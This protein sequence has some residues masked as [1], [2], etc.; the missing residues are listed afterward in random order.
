M[1]RSV[2]AASLAAL[3]GCTIQ[4]SPPPAYPAQQPQTAQQEPP[5]P[6]PPDYPDQH[7][8]HDHD[9]DRHRD[10]DR[11]RDRHQHRPP[12][13]SRPVEPSRPVPP[14]PPPT[15]PV[16]PP[17]VWN[18]TGWVLLGETTVSGNERDTIRVGRRG[19]YSAITLVASDGDFEMADAVVTFDTGRSFSPNVKHRFR[20]GDRTRAIDL[21][22]EARGLR[23]VELVYGVRG[24]GRVQVWGREGAAPLPPASAPTWDTRGWTLLGDEAIESTSDRDT[25]RVDPRRKYSALMLVAVSGEFEMADAVVTFDTGRSFSPNVK[26]TFRAGQRTAPIDLPGEARGLKGSR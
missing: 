4:S 16:P 9:H 22:G 21:P 20:E 25:F 10:R 2:L 19:Q 12:A 7:G 24:A 3:V 6:P 5:P 1:V 15:R 11:D 18:S 26:Q 23:S 8:D 17:P 14:P 13:P